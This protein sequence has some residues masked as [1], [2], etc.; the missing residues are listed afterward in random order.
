M[1]QISGKWHS[2]ICNCGYCSVLRAET[3]SDSVLGKKEGMITTR[4]MVSRAALNDGKY[5]ERLKDQRIM[6]VVLAKVNV[7][8]VKNHVK[9]YFYIDGKRI[10][11]ATAAL[12]LRNH[13]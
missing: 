6:T 5:S 9:G 7:P 8:G 11:R 1:V 3:G 4:D 10:T 13:T 2:Y 12:I